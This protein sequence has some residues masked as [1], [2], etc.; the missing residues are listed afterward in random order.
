MRNT[1]LRRQKSRWWE[2]VQLIRETFIIF[3]HRA[4][5]SRRGCPRVWPSR[6]GSGGQPGE[7]P[8]D[9]GDTPFGIRALIIDPRV[10]HR[11]GRHRSI[12]TRRRPAPISRAARCPPSPSPPPPSPPLPRWFFSRN[13]AALSGLPGPAN[14][15]SR[16]RTSQDRI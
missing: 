15:S 9:H 12:V 1:F 10:D 11:R 14:P 2:C 16:H 7:H 4:T 6:D 8:L 13:S 5:S 3:V